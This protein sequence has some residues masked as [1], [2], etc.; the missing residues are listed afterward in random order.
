MGTDDLSD[1]T[2]DQARQLQEVATVL[3]KLGDA[4]R[5]NAAGAGRVTA[6]TGSALSAARGGSDV[7]G[8]AVERMAE[9]REASKRVAD[10]TGVID[11][12]AFQTNILAL[13][14]AVEAA[15]AGEQ[16]RGFAV[17]ASE[18]RALAQR[19]AS[20]AREIKALIEDAR[21]RQAPNSSKAPA[22]QWATSSK[23]SAASNTPCTRSPT[24]RAARNRASLRS[25]RC[26][27]ESRKP[28]SRT[29]R[30]RGGNQRR[31]RQP[32]QQA[33][34]LSN[35]APRFVAPPRGNSKLK[36]V[37]TAAA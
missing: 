21:C 33:D 1:R 24:P 8:Q 14:A 23:A 34:G 25:T 3:A 4:V 2:E 7:V 16:G 9:I 20:S 36:P 37:R 31:H 10:I 15:R 6:A 35:A 30:A 18:V 12:I 5:D 17:V 22:A 27:A 19:S 29:S 11:A 13:N 32:H 28:P 26:S